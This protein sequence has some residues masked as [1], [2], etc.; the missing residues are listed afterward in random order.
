MHDKSVVTQREVGVDAQSFESALVNAMRQAPDL[1]QI[2]EIRTRETMESA[3]V[4]AETGHLCM[5]TL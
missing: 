3:L 4:L 1:I 2:D 5:A